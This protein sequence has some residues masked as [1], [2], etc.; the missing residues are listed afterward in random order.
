VGVCGPIP[1]PSAVNKVRGFPGHRQNKREP[2]ASEFKAK[3]PEHL[4]ERAVAEWKRL[5]PILK[6][7]KVLREPDYIALEILCQSYSTMVQAQEKLS[8][9]GLIYT[10]PGSGYIQQSP[11]LSIVN[12]A[13]ATVSKQLRE[14]GLTPAARTRIQATDNPSDENKWAKF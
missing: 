10:A 4:D 9:S 7:M 8:Q 1:V 3:P 6:R 14:F 2:E 5:V 13:A 11:L 12:Q